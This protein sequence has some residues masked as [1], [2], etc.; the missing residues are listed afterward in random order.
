[1]LGLVTSIHLP[2][3]RANFAH[4]PLKQQ[5][6]VDEVLEIGMDVDLKLEKMFGLK[7]MGED[8]WWL[9]LGF[10]RGFELLPP[11]PNAKGSKDGQRLFDLYARRHEYRVMS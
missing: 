6:A 7:P 1:M 2:M 9:I 3:S 11:S 10:L 4:L 5:K 8:V